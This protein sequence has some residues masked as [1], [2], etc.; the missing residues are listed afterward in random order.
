MSTITRERFCAIHSRRGYTVENIGL[1]TFLSYEDDKEEYTAMWFW[2]ADGTLN[3]EMKPSW[4]IR[5][6]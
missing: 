2:N 6:K 1:V 3:T 4:N 5:R